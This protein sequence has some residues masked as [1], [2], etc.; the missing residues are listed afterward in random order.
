MITTNDRNYTYVGIVKQY[1]EVNSFV[2]VAFSSIKLYAN[3]PAN[4]AANAQYP[5]FQTLLK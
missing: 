5:I 3:L 2:E 4:Q 1:A